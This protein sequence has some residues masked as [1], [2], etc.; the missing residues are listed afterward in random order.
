MKHLFLA[1]E[2]KKV[3]RRE[4]PNLTP[5]LKRAAKCSHLHHSLFP[6]VLKSKQSKRNTHLV[7]QPLET[8]LSQ[9]NV[10]PLLKFAVSAN[11]RKANR[12]YVRFL[13]SN[14]KIKAKKTNTPMDVTLA[15]RAVS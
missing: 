3:T 8:M 6:I 11:P 1:K 13:S 9:K 12:M 15:F 5:R 2:V 14:K 7:S 10:F 4:C